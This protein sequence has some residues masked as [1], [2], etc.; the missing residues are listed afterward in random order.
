MIA[1]AILA[2]VVAAIM[3]LRLSVA[4]IRR[5]YLGIFASEMVIAP[6][7]VGAVLTTMAAVGLW[8][9]TAH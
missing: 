4:V 8:W 1:I 2:T 6:M 7:A 3:A 9:T 5:F